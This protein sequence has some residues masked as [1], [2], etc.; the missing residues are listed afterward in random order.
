MQSTDIKYGDRIIAHLFLRDN[1]ELEWINFLTPQEYPLQLWIME[2]KEWRHVPPHVHVDMNYDVNITQEFLYVEK[3]EIEISFYSDAEKWEFIWKYTLK[4]WDFVLSVS[5]WHE[6][7]I[8]PGSGLI[9]VKQWPY[10]GDKY[11]KIFKS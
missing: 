4:K 8:K 1:E 5:W 3:W 7:N 11:A 2:Y 10:P 6:V 9:E